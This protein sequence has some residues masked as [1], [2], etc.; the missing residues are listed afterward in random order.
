MLKFNLIED[1]DNSEVTIDISKNPTIQ[2]VNQMIKD[3]GFYGIEVAVFSNAYTNI[4]GGQ[5][6]IFIDIDA[7]S[8]MNLYCLDYNTKLSQFELRTTYYNNSISFGPKDSGLDKLT[9]DLKKLFDLVNKLDSIDFKKLR[10][11]LIKEYIK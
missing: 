8:Y 10:A 5:P 7:Y 11:D 1:I 2:K 3:A 4:N 9:T 6:D